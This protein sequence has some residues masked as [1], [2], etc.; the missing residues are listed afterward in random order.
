[1]EKRWT[2]SESPQFK[3]RGGIN[4]LQSSFQVKGATATPI[5]A[6]RQAKTNLEWL[7]SW[8]QSIHNH[9]TINFTPINYALNTTER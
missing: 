7:S 5:P 4:W 6:A 8:I 2:R 9:L 1:M 3:K